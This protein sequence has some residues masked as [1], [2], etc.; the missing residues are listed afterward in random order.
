MPARCPTTERASPQKGTLMPDSTAQYDSTALTD[1]P[2]ECFPD[3]SDAIRA[4]IGALNAITAYYAAMTERVRVRANR[5]DRMEFARGGA[6]PPMEKQPV[7]EALENLNTSGAQHISNPE[8][9][10]GG[11][12][13]P[14]K[15]EMINTKRGP[16]SAAITFAWSP[17]EPHHLSRNE[18]LELR[19]QLSQ[20]LLD[21]AKQLSPEV[22]A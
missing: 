17:D 19:D 21:S 1:G 11:V 20:F 18:V 9:A 6:I 15:V 16:V 22:K 8:F 4:Q 12:I 7:A 2:F 13:Y 5:T 3:D 10:R 14:T